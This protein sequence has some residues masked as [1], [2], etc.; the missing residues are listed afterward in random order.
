MP[1]HDAPPSSTYSPE[2]AG[3][4]SADVGGA[5]AEGD[6][7]G[8]GCSVGACAGGRAVCVRRAQPAKAK[9]AKVDASP[10]RRYTARSWRKARIDSL[11]GIAGRPGI[12][13]QYPGSLVCTHFRYDRNALL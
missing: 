13:M 1:Y 4:L 12:L 2:A 7:T 5:E 9:T 11:G 6:G 3:R 8:A 10:S